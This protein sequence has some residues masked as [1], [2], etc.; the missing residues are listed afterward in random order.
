MN[1][2]TILFP[3]VLLC[4]L[5]PVYPAV[6]GNTVQTSK[7]ADWITAHDVSKPADIPMDA[8][9]GGV[10]YLLTDKQIRVLEGRQPMAYSH[11]ADLVVN[12]QGLDELSQI[13]IEYDP[14]Y[15]SLQFRDGKLIDKL[16][17]TKISVI[18]RETDLENQLYDGRLTANIIIDDLRVGDIV[19]YS[20]T[21]EGENPVYNNIFAYERSVEWSVP[22]YQQRIRV[23]WGKAKQL[24]VNTIN[25][26]VKIN[27]RQ[28]GSLTEYSVE[29]DNSKPVYL[30]SE[31]PA[32][33]NPHAMVFFSES[34]SWSEIALWA[35]P[36]YQRAIESGPELA[37]VVDGIRDKYKD[38]AQQI[39]EALKFVQGEIRYL[40]I[41]MGK[42]SHEPTPAD[43]TLQRRYG[44]CKDKTVLFISLLKLLGVEASPALVNTEITRHISKYPPV[45]DAFDHVI[46]KVRFDDKVYWL[47]PTRQ[48][49]QGRLQDIYQPDYG[50]ALVINRKTDVLERMHK[51]PGYS[52]LVV[53]DRFDLTKGGNKDV[54][55]EASTRYF[56]Y[57]AEKLRYQIADLGMT[58]LQDSYKDFYSRYYKSVKPLMK[59][60]ITEDKTTGSML[61]KEKY[62]LAKFWETNTEDREYNAIF[63]ANSIMPRLA[64]PDQLN[65]TSPYAIE[66]PV[67]I[68]QTIDVV[69]GSKN[70]DFD[71]EEFVEDN[72]FFFYEAKVKYDRPSKTLRLAYE[73]V[74]RVDHVAVAEFDEYMA[75]RARARDNAKYGI[76]EYFS[77]NEQAAEDKDISGQIINIAI[78]AYIVAFVFVIVNWRYDA[79]KQPSFEE[80]AY[81]PVSLAKLIILSIVTCGVYDAY[82]F[83][84]NWLYRKQY[85]GSA[86]M[87]VAR[88]IFSYFWYYPLYKSLVTDS[89]ARFQENRVLLRSLAILFA[90]IYLAANIAT[91]DDSLWVPAF[92]VASLTLIPLA[93]YI[94]HINEGNDRAYAYN[95]RWL[96]RHS[97][98]VI[99]A[100]PLILYAGGASLY[101]VP[102]DEVVEGDK[103]MSYDIKFMHRKGLFPAGERVIYFYS[104][105][106]LNIRDDGNGFT[107]KHVFSYWKDDRNA[108]NYE[109]AQFSKVKNIDVTF[110]RNLVENTIVTIE[111]EDGSDFLL[112]VSRE[113]GLDKKFVDEL[114]SRWH[115]LRDKEKH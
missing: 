8:I 36:L 107:D 112:Y 63:Y 26:D 83:Y 55:Y 65:R 2:K 35:L 73:Y 97:V 17:S 85:D 92:I 87:P 9:E 4:N 67:N 104:D 19:E 64:K 89:T 47:D 28:L 18:Q 16:P 23:L 75:A 100:A 79:R 39:V 69:F 90:L 33:Y 58:G 7:A 88:G 78:F 115:Q 110:S 80:A 22:V 76:A 54:I 68:K 81:Y 72:K 11:Y 51:N 98:L 91:G 62:Q 101:L 57:R 44:D 86:I 37:A 59:L 45:I 70:W 108:F 15:Q 20:F 21:R 34:G 66:Y 96:L 3:L 94:N 103:I 40:G 93:N 31:I 56:G 102:R 53:N 12:Q 5:C 61:Q 30:N 25:S 74:S 106:F 60:E 1:I 41:E 114:K 95:S 71:D 82:W 99:L 49:Q 105:A 13:N 109:T 43:D 27:K 42:N 50:Y 24:H 38:P 32:W 6:A 113:K 29:Y 10:Y 14:T 46:V 48:Y 84:R 77:G 52:K 111:R